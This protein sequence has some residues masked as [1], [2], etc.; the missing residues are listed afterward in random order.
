MNH[1]M[2]LSLQGGQRA[3]KIILIVEDDESIGELLALAITQE[4]DYQP[5]IAR[6]SRQALEVISQ[7]KPHLLLID[8]YLPPENGLELYDHI[9]A[10]HGYEAIPA[11]FLTLGDE[12][13]RLTFEERHLVVLEKPFDLDSLLQA[14]EEQLH[15]R[16]QAELVL[17]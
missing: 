15:S 10:R 17:S 4:S 2:Q 7:V 16:C 8:Y 9:V 12:E 13:P 14:I 6:T 5:V 1:P 3:G 11:I